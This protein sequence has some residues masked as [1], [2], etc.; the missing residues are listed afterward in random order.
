MTTYELFEPLIY[1]VVHFEIVRD[2]TIRLIF[3]DQ[4]EQI[5]NFEPILSGPVFG[6]LKDKALF[7]KVKLEEAFGTLEWPNGA[8][9]SPEVL[10]DW[11]EHEAAIITRRQ[12]D[13]LWQQAA[14]NF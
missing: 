6:P 8:D 5:I 13:G 12:Q 4:T 3:E 11:A 14:T 1:R 7:N 2:Y 9:I 10:H